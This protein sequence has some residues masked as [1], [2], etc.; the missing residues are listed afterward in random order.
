MTARMTRRDVLYAIPGVFGLGALLRAQQPAGAFNTI[1]MNH[2]TLAVTN[3]KRSQEV[4]QR[5]FGLPIVAAEGTVPIMRLGS[6]PQVI[7]LSERRTGKPR[8][9]HDW[10]TIEQF[11][12]DRVMK[13]IAG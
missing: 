6:G 11:E 5:L 1:A 12:V 8:I 13:P 10:R 9:E 2:V 3:A 7:A 4:Y